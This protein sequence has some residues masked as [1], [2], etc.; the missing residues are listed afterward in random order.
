MVGPPLAAGLARLSAY[1]FPVELELRRLMVFWTGFDGHSTIVSF[2]FET[3]WFPGSANPPASEAQRSWPRSKA[4]AYPPIIITSHN[5]IP[6]A[7]VQRWLC[8]APWRTLRYRR[9]RSNM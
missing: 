1:D 3:V 9:F 8:S 4:T 7:S 2:V 5:R 6:A